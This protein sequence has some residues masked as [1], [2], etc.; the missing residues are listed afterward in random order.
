MSAEKT[1]QI[2]HARRVFL[3]GVTAASLTACGF[4]PRGSTSL[5]PDLRRVSLAGSQPS[6]LTLALERLLRQGGADIN[7]TAPKPGDSLNIRIN[8]VQLQRREALIDR[9][10]NVRQIELI[11]RALVSASRADGQ[12]ILSQEAF[13]AVRSVSY[14]PLARLAQ[15]EEEQ[16][17][18][19]ELDEQ[20]AQTIL[21]RLRSRLATP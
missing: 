1:H 15:G 13:E 18:Q 9:Q 3:L 16:R 14:N 4:Q 7:S 19:R 5:P 11:Q 12:E 20:M 8:N 6:G 17:L 21:A 2:K 10:A